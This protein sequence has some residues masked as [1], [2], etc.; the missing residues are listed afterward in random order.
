MTFPAGDQDNYAYVVPGG[1][2]TLTA[3]FQTHYYSGRQLAVSGVELTITPVAGGAVTGPVTVPDLR[4]LDEAT[5]Q[6][7]WLPPAGTTP[8]DYEA[9]WSGNGPDG[10]LT[11]AQGVTVVPIPAEAPSP[12]L[13]C[14]IAQYRAET[15]DMLTPDFVIQRHLR[16]ACDIIDQ[17][18]ISAVYPTDADSMPVLAAHINLF[19]RATAAQIEFMI[20][21][22]DP[23]NVKPQYAST[24][25]GGISQTRT[26]SAAGGVTP[27]LAPAAAIILQGDGAVPGAAL[28]GW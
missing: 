28:I 12:G 20:A 22:A 17:A 14:T 27:R 4:Q 24:S 15:T 18:L 16:R 1:E 11:I 6:Y 5:Y 13:Y 19:M 9:V 3:Q 2:I 7:R 10:T 26:P 25:V 23:A 8:G 21:N